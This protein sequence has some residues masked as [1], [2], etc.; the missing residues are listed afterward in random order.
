MSFTPPARSTWGIVGTDP[1]VNFSNKDLE[2][3]ILRY[4][5]DNWVL[6]EDVPNQIPVDLTK[7]NLFDLNATN[8]P[9]AVNEP[10]KFDQNY[11]IWVEAR[12]ERASRS[13]EGSTLGLTGWIKHV[14]VFWIHLYARRF[15]RQLSFP[16][17]GILQEEVERILFQYTITRQVNKIPGV[18]QFDNWDA[19]PVLDQGERDAMFLYQKV[20]QIECFYYRAS[21]EEAYTDVV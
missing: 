6:V 7:D 9:L 2:D 3:R 12:R 10:F 16:E 21:S 1:V 13:D 19:G 15:E 5:A 14:G 20:C 11:W 17:L 18:I 4:I 8:K